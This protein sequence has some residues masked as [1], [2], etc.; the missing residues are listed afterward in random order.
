MALC[1]ACF[2]QAQTIG[3]YP[4]LVASRWTF[5]RSRA[6][7]HFSTKCTPRTFSVT[8]LPETLN[9]VT[10]TSMDD[11]KNCSW[12][13]T[14]LFPYLG[15]TCQLMLRLQRKCCLRYR[16]PT[17]FQILSP[18]YTYKTLL[19]LAF[20]LL[21]YQISS[22]DEKDI[23]LMKALSS[24]LNVFWNCFPLHE[25]QFFALGEDKRVDDLT[26]SANALAKQ[27]LG[28][29]SKRNTAFA[30]PLSIS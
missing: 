20:S 3:R 4:I 29:F 18:Q 12:T 27:I 22:A 11:T 9:N 24:V 28:L 8:S 23:Q 13:W 1:K 16:M 7:V 25:K 14:S 19:S 17:I 30:S 2:R 10:L 26:L 6:H 5:P 21:P 15:L